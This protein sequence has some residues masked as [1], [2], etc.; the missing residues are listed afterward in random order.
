MDADQQLRHGDS[1]GPQES[2]KTATAGRDSSHQ[3]AARLLL[4][5]ALLALGLYTLQNFIRALAW[6]V[7]LGIALWPL[8]RRARR[9][10]G[11]K[12]HDIVLPALFTLAVAVI[13]ALPLAALA[14]E[15]VREARDLLDYARQAEQ[16]GVPVPA[17][18]SQM[19]YGAAAASR[20]WTENL[21]HA[22]WARDL[23][24]RLDTASARE[25]GQQIGADVV[26][27]LVLFVFALLA[28]F[29]IFRDGDTLIAQCRIA[30]ER[31]FGPRG[32]RIARQMAASVHGTLD[33]LVFVGLGEGLVMGVIYWLAGVPHPILL[34]AV[35]AIA[36][37][38]PFGAAVAVALAAVL[39]LGV[40]AVGA[41]VVVVVAGLTVIFVADHFVRPA[42][43][44]GTTRLPFLWVLLGILGGAESF[45]LLGL[46][47]GPAVMAALMLLWREFTDG[48]ERTA[49]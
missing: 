15:A 11:A 8:F 22:G 31:L 19:P 5:A 20:W 37:M 39:L 4:A 32:E 42:L 1:L 38:I 7:V 13:L 35:T 48:G 34:G 24:G 12:R 44:G 17:F 28:L 43:I 16:T 45:G 10:F 2:T 18:V 25:F 3:L 46:F 26:H 36:A 41:A 6:A 30:G 27:R 23:L 9:R 49:P 14:V 29:F 21:A 40:N 33:G 47:V